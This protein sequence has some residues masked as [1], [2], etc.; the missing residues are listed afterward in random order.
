MQ[1]LSHLKRRRL[2]QLSAFCNRPA[3][4]Q[5]GQSLAESGFCPLARRLQKFIVRCPSFDGARRQNFRRY[6]CK[7]VP[8]NCGGC[9][10]RWSKFVSTKR[11]WSRCIWKANCRP[12]FKKDWPL[13]SAQAPCPEKCTWPQARSQWPLGCARICAKTT[14]WWVHT[15]RTTL[16]FPTGRTVML[17]AP[18]RRHSCK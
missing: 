1:H 4:R 13:T 16:P 14:P 15:A 18:P 5:S 12:P 7:Q 9:T 17:D 3:A 10:K 11:P 6:A 8:S 2:H